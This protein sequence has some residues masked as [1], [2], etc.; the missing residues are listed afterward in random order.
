MF[1]YSKW[2]RPFRLLD[3]NFVRIS[4]VLRSTHCHKSTKNPTC[5]ISCKILS[6][7]SLSS[8]KFNSIF[9]NPRKFHLILQVQVGRGVGNEEGKVMVS[10]LFLICSRDEL[11]SYCTWADVRHYHCGEI[12]YGSNFVTQRAELRQNLER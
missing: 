8:T 6:C 5:I 10:G 1:E 2:V 7:L 9:D 12:H 3:E 11:S 4:H